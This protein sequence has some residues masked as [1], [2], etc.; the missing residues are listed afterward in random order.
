VGKVIIKFL[1][2]YGL[3][4]NDIKIEGN[5]I[6]VDAF[7]APP[8]WKL[9]MNGRSVMPKPDD[10]YKT[11]ESLGNTIYGDIKDIFDSS[12]D[13][14][15]ITGRS[16]SLRGFVERE[17]YKMDIY[18]NKG[19]YMCPNYI[20]GSDNIA[21]WKA[22]VIGNLLNKYD[23]V[24]FYEDKKNWADKVRKRNSSEN[25]NVYLIE[26]GKIIKKY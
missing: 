24:H 11:K 8:E 23:E 9:N 2:S 13:Q 6:T 10:Y 4:V 21:E 19:V 18:P 20:K 17:L 5:R 15:I 22:K 16:E 3:D 1:D 7:K 12:N 26:N 14:V 25:L